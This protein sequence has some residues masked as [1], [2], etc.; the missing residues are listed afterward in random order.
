MNI[1]ERGLDLIKEFEGYLRPLKDGGC[2]AYRCPAGVWTLGWGCTKGIKPGMT[3]TKQQAVEGLRRELAECEAAVTRMV[4]API[5]Q[6]QFD[7]LVSF[8]YNCGIAA[9]QKSTILRKLN[10][11]DVEGAAAAFE[12]WNKATVNGKR[13]VLRGLARRR[14]AEKALFLTP[15]EEAEPEPMPQSVAEPPAVSPGA[16][17]VGGTG[18]IGGGALL[19][20]PAGVTSTAVAVKA[21]AGQLLSGVDLVTWGVPLVICVA[22]LAFLY[23]SRKNG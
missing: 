19:A 6:H 9:L 18:I 11:G 1:S 12:M 4:T 10:R 5:H 23:W 20:D 22:V 8:A 7:A 17:A 3:W 13:V 14:A 16:A 21:N 2:I 15:P